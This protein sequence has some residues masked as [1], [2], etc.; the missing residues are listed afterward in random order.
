MPALALFALLPATWAYWA[1]RDG[2]YYPADWYPGELLA[3]ALVVVLVLARVPWALSRHAR[4]AIGALTALAAWT[5]L[6]M[7]WSP[8]AGSALDE[9]H[10]VVMY[11]ATFAAAALLGGLLGTRRTTALAM[12]AAAAGV[13]AVMTVIAIARTP[14]LVQEDGVLRHPLGYHNAA[15]AFWLVGLWPALATALRRDLAPGWRGLAAGGAALLVALAVLCQSRGS[16]VALLVAAAVFVAASADRRRALTAL[17]MLTAVVAPAAPV[18]LGGEDAAW[19][20]AACAAGAVA[21]GWGAA[22]RDL[23]PIV[24]HRARRPGGTRARV[25]VVAALALTGLAAQPLAGWA[26][27]RL[28]EF[29]SSQQPQFSGSRFQ[30]D[31]GSGRYDFWRVALHDGVAAPVWGTGAGGFPGSYLLQRRTDEQVTDPHSLPLRMLAELG[32]PGLLLAGGFVVGAF[33]GVARV[34]RVGPVADDASV[35]VLAAGAYWLVH[36]SVDW[37]WTYPAVTAMG[38]GM[39]G[40]LSSWSPGARPARGPRRSR[41]VAIGATVLASIAAVP[42]A[43]SARLTEGAYDGW[44]R[45]PQRAHTAL[46]RAQRLNPLALEPHVAQGT[47]ATRGGDRALAIASFREA[48]RLQPGNWATHHRLAEALAAADRPTAVRESAIAVR[49]NPRNRSAADLHQRLTRRY[50]NG[51]SAVDPLTGPLGGGHVPDDDST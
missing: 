24:A 49:L 9:G 50:P 39:L 10:R 27:T 47:M 51:E 21:V 13:I 2:G 41:A 42:P 16:A 46:D 44:W 28:D 7:L 17:G 20:L 6:S 40:L 5:F 36:A 22:A 32:V 8:A 25:A 31:A 35:A 3:L 43:L 29:T 15:A 38:V 37:L 19:A 1:W 48:A 30:L 11:L 26:Q 4:L 33:G 23:G 12:V 18:L 45:A 34:R 14:G